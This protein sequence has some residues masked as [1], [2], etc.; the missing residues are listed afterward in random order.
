[1]VQTDLTT[2]TGRAARRPRRIEQVQRPKRVKRAWRPKRTRVTW[3]HIWVRRTWELKQ[4]DQARQPTPSQV[5]PTT[6]MCRA[7]PT[8]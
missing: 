3:W 7:G 2:Q 5:D 1:M 8:T 6:K 4:V